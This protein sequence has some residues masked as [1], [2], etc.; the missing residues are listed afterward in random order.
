[1]EPLRESD[2]RDALAELA[3]RLSTKRLQGRL[4]IAEGT[5]M[6]LAHDSEKLTRDIDAAILHGHGPVIDSVRNIA[7]ARG[8]PST[9]LNEQATPYM[10]QVPDRYGQLVFDHP[11]LKVVAASAAHMLAMKVR[12]A[13]SSDVADTRRLLRQTGLSD[14][15]QV[16][17]LVESVFPG[18]RLGDRARRWLEDVL[19]GTPPESLRPL[20]PRRIPIRC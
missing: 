15:I 12:A 11:A 19:Q 16:E 20:D 7:R 2:I 6:A 9:W 13:R 18:E 3:D 4:Y 1:M 10:P 17:E 14:I 5:A 8:R